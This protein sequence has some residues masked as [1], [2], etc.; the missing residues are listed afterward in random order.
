[1]ANYIL[2]DVMRAEAF[3][4]NDEGKFVHYFDANTMTESTI[5]ISTT[6]E[7]I[8]GG[9]GNQLLG[10]IFHDS[11][12]GVNLTEAMWSLDYLAAQIGS[13]IKKG[14]TFDLKYV[15]AKVGENGSIS[16]TVGAEEGENKIK[17]QIVAMFKESSFCTSTDSLIAW[18]KGCDDKM[19][20]F[21]VVP[22]AEASQPATAY[23][24]NPI[25]DTLKKDDVVCVTYPVASTNCDQILVK[26]AYAPKEFSLYLYGKIFAGNGC[27]KS[28]GKRVGKFVIEIPRFQLDGTVDLTMN[29]SS[30]ATTALNGSALAY[31]CTCNG[32]NEYAKISIVLDKVAGGE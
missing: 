2:G 12:F 9:W 18:G 15:T 6:A 20:T 5:N 3:A 27:Q 29:P 19:Y 23:T 7:G 13:D 32:E 11:N 30:A 17:D 28:K 8:R 10:K 14:E 22:T 26:A 1:M 16:L 24:L 4:V 21:E 31:G 25:G